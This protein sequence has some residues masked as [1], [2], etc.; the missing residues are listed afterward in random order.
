MLCF[1]CIPSRT[2]H[3]P[4]SLVLPWVLC[5][6][7]ENVHP[8]ARCLTPNINQGEHRTLVPRLA[9]SPYQ[10]TISGPALPGSCET[11]LLPFSSLSGF[12][13]GSSLSV[14]PR[15]HC[16]NHFLNLVSLHLLLSPGVVSSPWPLYKVPQDPATR[17]SSIQGPAFS[18]KPSSTLS[19]HPGEESFFFFFNI[20]LFICFGS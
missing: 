13:L 12:H 20:Y 16:L 8:V 18:T 15:G 9:P 14:P 19:Y 1:Q 10:D 3:H 17:S 7:L 11:G 4:S 2:L 6:G 5:P